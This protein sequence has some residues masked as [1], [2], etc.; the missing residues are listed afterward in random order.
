MTDKLIPKFIF[1][2]TKSI[3][4]DHNAIIKVQEALDKGVTFF[5]LNVKS[6]DH[7]SKIESIFNIFSS[8]KVKISNEITFL[9]DIPFPYEKTR[10]KDINGKSEW[11]I[12]NGEQIKVISEEIANT[13]NQGDYL[14]VDSEFMKCPLKLS[15]KIVFGDGEGIFEVVE[16]V[17]SQ[18]LILKALND[19]MIYR[20]KALVYNT[21]KKTFLRDNDLEIL[22]RILNGKFNILLVLSFVDEVKYIREIANKLKIPQNRIICKI[23]NEAGIKNVVNILAESDGIMI[24]RG[25]LGINLG[26]A[27]LYHIEQ[28]LT[29]VANIYKK[30]SII[31][32]DILGSLINRGMP[33]RA[34]SIDMSVILKL[35]PYGV[36]FKAGLI[37]QGKIDLYLSTLN[38]F[39]NAADDA[40]IKF[41]SQNQDVA[42][43]YAGHVKAG[44][45]TVP[46]YV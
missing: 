33:C 2:L 44:L 17:S 20:N 26:V 7:L 37:E 18:Q 36:V 45:E 31:A 34:D 19:F 6:M 9:L 43:A 12:R 25:D 1:T 23:E 32:T 29:K 16:I 5:R 28:Y 38:E 15:S 35:K 39:I 41:F 46:N 22:K 4:C 8:D 14:V 3:L 11:Y 42:T 27:N 40:N 13:D 24:A 21:L 10:I 30:K